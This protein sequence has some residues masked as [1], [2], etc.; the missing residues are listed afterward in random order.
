MAKREEF[1][2][3]G[4]RLTLQGGGVEAIKQ[5]GAWGIAALARSFYML[6]SRALK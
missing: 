1:G 2:G 3:D 4:P 6:G 5:H